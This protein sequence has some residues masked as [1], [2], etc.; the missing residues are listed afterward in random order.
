MPILVETYPGYRLITLNRPDRLNALTVEMAD[1]LVAA[2]DAAEA[3]QR[4][5]A[6]L[7]TGAGRGASRCRCRSCPGPRPLAIRSGR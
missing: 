4:C 2:L 6:V 5:R 3:D 1:A 7:L